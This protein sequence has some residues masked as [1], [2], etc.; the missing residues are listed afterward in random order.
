MRNKKV[1]GIIVAITIML[2]VIVIVFMMIPVADEYKYVANNTE[3]T[4]SREGFYTEFIEIITK[5]NDSENRDEQGIQYSSEVGEALALAAENELEFYT[6][7]NLVGGYRYWYWLDYIPDL[8]RNGIDID[9]KI[10]GRDVTNLDDYR[11]NGM[12]MHANIEEDHS[13]WNWCNA[14]VSC[15]AHEA[16]VSTGVSDGRDGTGYVNVGMSC[17]RTLKFFSGMDYADIIILDTS[18]VSS[19]A[20]YRNYVSKLASTERITVVDGETF[21]PSRGD[22]IFYS[23]DGVNTDHIGIVTASN[24]ESK[25]FTTIEGNLSGEGNAKASVVKKREHSVTGSSYQKIMGYVHINAT[26]E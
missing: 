17:Q 25:T 20:N 6:S 23:Y 24:Q 8:I 11:V 22:L 10:G 21:V 7:N 12:Y 14:F 19:E 1:L 4:Y 26:C 16:G 18:L 5:S 13:W 3:S 15:C 2:C 9:E